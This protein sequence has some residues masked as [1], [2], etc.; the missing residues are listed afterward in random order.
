[1]AAGRVPE[2]QDPALQAALSLAGVLRVVA[3]D[4]DHEFVV[5]RHAT[6]TGAQ[7]WKLADDIS[8]AVVK[9]RLLS[10]AFHDGCDLIVAAA[11]F[12]LGDQD[13]IEPAVMAFLNSDRVV[14]WLKWLT[15]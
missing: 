1:V 15:L 8:R 14:R 6:A 10:I 2:G 3:L 5:Q 7:G 11:T 9:R 4:L 13:A 12:E